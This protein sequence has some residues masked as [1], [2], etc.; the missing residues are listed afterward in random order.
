M[1][2]IGSLFENRFEILREIGQGGMGTVYLVRDVQS[3]VCYALKEERITD[4]NR[5]L[6][7]SEAAI[8]EKLSH[9][10]LPKLILKKEQKEFL[11]L[12]MEY[13]D[14]STLEDIILDNG[15]VDEPLVIDWFIQVGEV[16][17]YL[18]SLETPVVY[19]D[20][21][22]SN[23]MLEKSGKIRIIDFGIAQEYQDQS[24]KVEVAALTRGYAAPEQY[25]R[26]YSLDV[27]TDIYALAV[28]MHYLLTGKDPN[29]PPYV[30]RPVRKLRHDVSY[31][32]EHIIKKCLQPN[33]DRRYAN[34]ELL[35]NDLHSINTLEKDL[36][37]RENW[38]RVLTISTAALVVIVSLIAY[39]FNFRTRKNEI[40]QY[41]HYIEQASESSSLE[42]AA[43]NITL[44]IELSPDNP[45]AYIS[46]AEILIKH[47]RRNEAVDYINET[48]IIEF[49]DIYENNDFLVLIQEIENSQ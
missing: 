29:Q 4:A 43:Q 3:S 14:G 45:E 36:R 23:I 25:D 34:V 2:E 26:R 37:S 10:A 47:D 30:F 31:S 13:I 8:M 27:R 44:A 19:R 6:L 24:A 11:Y 7:L 42:E 15:P 9:L 38:K 33:P 35:L 20:L 32:I 48:I 16:L 49:P 46:Y 12:V 39:Y 18:H 28:T 22:P 17:R 40:Q 1:L 5:S 41:Y 21:K